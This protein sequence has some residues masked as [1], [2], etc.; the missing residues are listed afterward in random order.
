MQIEGV[1]VE[2]GEIDLEVAGVNDD[3][4][5]R[6]DG[7]GHTINQRMRYANR[8]DGERAEGELVFGLDLDELDFVEELVFVELAFDVGQG[9]LGAVNRDLELGENPR[10]AADMVFVAV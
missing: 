6:F 3:A 8:L 9:E 10:Q 2:R 4:D 5:R 1:I 7:Q